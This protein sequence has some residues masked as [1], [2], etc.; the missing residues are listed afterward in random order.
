MTVLITLTVAGADSGPFNLYSNLDGYVI[1][2]AIGISK[3]ALQAGYSS[4]AVPDYTT[5]VRIKSEGNCTNY[6]DVVLT[7][8]TTTTTTS[9]SSTTTTSTTLVC[10]SYIL[11]APGVSGEFNTADF[12]DCSGQPNSI[13]AYDYQNIVFCANSITG[14]SGGVAYNGPCN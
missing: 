6:I 10:N 1:P 2:F 12:I 7:T 8:P 13:T 11:S 5:I 3:A 4:L 14:G 9:S